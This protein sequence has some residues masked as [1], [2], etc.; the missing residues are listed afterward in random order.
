LPPSGSVPVSEETAG[1]VAQEL[2]S[3]YGSHAWGM[4][5]ERTRTLTTEGFHSLAKTWERIRDAIETVQSDIGEP[6]RSAPLSDSR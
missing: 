4:A 5:D 2:L 6:C 3:K 1:L